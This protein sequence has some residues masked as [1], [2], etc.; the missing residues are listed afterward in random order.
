M[1]AVLVS[2]LASLLLFP[3]RIALK[4]INQC[5]RSA[6]IAAELLVQTNVHLTLAASLAMSSSKRRLLNNNNAFWK[7]FTKAR[8]S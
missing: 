5:V 7:L 4:F 1:I 8:N 6:L 3:Q 2:C